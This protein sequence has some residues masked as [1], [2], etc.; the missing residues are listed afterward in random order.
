MATTKKTNRTKS[1]NGTAPLWRY[2]LAGRK[3]GDIA[4]AVGVRPQH[5]ADCLYG[6]NSSRPVLQRTAKVLRCRLSDLCKPFTLRRE[7]GGAYRLEPVGAARSMKKT[8]G[9]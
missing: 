8:R 7:K 6:K 4:K 5:L 2:Y 1:S 9:P 3:Q